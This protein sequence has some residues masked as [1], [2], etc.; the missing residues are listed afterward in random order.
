MTKHILVSCLVTFFFG[1]PRSTGATK[2]GDPELSEKAQPVSRDITAEAMRQCQTAADCVPVACTCTCSGCGG[3][4]SEDIINKHSEQA[5][6]QQHQ[7]NPSRVICPD[8]C[9]RSRRLVCEAGRCG[10]VS[11]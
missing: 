5:W 3:F 6:Y 2:R 10:S 9:C 4:S 7:C 11:P 1:C 8:V